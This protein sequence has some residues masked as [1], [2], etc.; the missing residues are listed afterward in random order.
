MIPEK[1]KKFFDLVE[2]KKRGIEKYQELSK[3]GSQRRQKM[4]NYLIE[5]MNGANKEREENTR[6]KKYDLKR[7]PIKGTGA[8]PPFRNAKED[9]NGFKLN[10]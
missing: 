4:N 8:T 10:S 5:T 6:K 3:E 7:E 1:F 2:F 9:K